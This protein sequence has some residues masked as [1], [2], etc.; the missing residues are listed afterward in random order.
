MSSFCA[1]C[2]STKDDDHKPTIETDIHDNKT[3][4]CDNIRCCVTIN[5]VCKEI[6]EEEEEEE[7]E[8]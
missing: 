2:K 4:C 5:N 7:E 1:C 6:E 3:S 8:E